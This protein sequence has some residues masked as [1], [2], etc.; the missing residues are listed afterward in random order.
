MKR[1]LLLFIL[2]AVAKGVYAQSLKVKINEKGKYGYVDENGKEIVKCQYD[3]GEEFL[4]GAGRITKGNKYGYVN[5][6]GKVVIQPKYKTASYE[7][8]YYWLTDEKDN[9]EVYNSDFKK[10]V[11]LSDVKFY[12]PTISKGRQF[13][14]QTNS[15][16]VYVYDIESFEQSTAYK[17]ITIHNNNYG[18]EIYAVSDGYKWKI[19][20]GNFADPMPIRCE[21]ESKDELLSV[22]KTWEELCSPGFEYEKF[23]LNEDALTAFQKI[24]DLVSQ[25]G[26]TGN[27]NKTLPSFVWSIKNIKK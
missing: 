13:C 6:K 25:Y 19:M 22:Y 14:F 17:Y 16:N 21:M 2:F 4:N 24:V 26:V 10:M 7:G 5:E 3:F 27:I 1:I 18:S 8:D 12:L 9:L 15:G 23:I 20:D 11:K